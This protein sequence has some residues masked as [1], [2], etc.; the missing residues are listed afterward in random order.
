VK[1]ASTLFDYV[2]RKRAEVLAEKSADDEILVREW[3]RW[4]QEEVQQAL[5]GPHAER[6]AELIAK[7]KAAP[8]W[9]AID[10]AVFL[11]P[12]QEVD[13]HTKALAVR[14]VHA[15]V[16]HL[17]EKAGLCPYDDPIPSFDGG[18]Q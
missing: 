18:S 16:V 4:R 9:D 3:K 7:L 1:K 11:K 17:R 8:S 14:M 12:W 2:D 6:L 15:F 5:A 13:R 10:A